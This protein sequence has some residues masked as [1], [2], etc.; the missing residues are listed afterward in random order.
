MKKSGKFRKSPF[1]NKHHLGFPKLV[2]DV[3]R[4]SD[5]ILE[6]L[7][8]RF[9]DKTRNKEIEQ[10][11]LAQGKKVIYILNKIDLININDLKRDYDLTSIM[12]YVLLSCKLRV[13]LGKLR[14]RVKIEVKR[15]KMK[16]KRARVGVIGYPNT[17]KSSLIN[18]LSGRASTRTSAESGFTKAMQKI[19]FNKDIVILDTPGVFQEKENTETKAFALKKH[20]EIG[21]KTYDKVKNPDLVINS[22]MI[23][24]PGKIEKFYGIES[25][26]DVEVLLEKIGERMNYRKKGNEIDLDRAARHVLKAWQEGKIK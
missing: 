9:I 24:Y 5:I 10:I 17:G 16:G 14:E 7:D 2:R 25:N 4:T 26:G 22:L 15:L 11:V 12:P 1:T 13:G 21:V 20:A 6:V 19:R 23:Q 8:A 3:I 18:L